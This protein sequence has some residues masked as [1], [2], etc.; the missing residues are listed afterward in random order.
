MR[1]KAKNSVPTPI[2]EG[3]LKSFG[4]TDEDELLTIQGKVPEEVSSRRKKPTQS[5]VQFSDVLSMP[6]SEQAKFFLNAMWP[7]ISRNPGQAERIYNEW[8]VFKM[9][10]KEAHNDGNKDITEDGTGVNETVARVFLEKL[11]RAVSASD[12]KEKFREIDS[13]SDGS[14]AWIEY[15]CYDN[16]GVSP[17][18]VIYRPQVQSSALYKSIDKVIAAER[19]LR[20]FDHDIEDLTEKSQL[21]GTEG[22]KY[23]ADLNKYKTEN[24]KAN[25]NADL[26]SAQE[27]LLRSFGKCKE[28]GT[29]FWESMLEKDREADKPQRKRK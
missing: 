27:G 20:Q 24:S 22:K 5:V 8:K 10:Q 2:K 13:N 11:K 18:T 3:E 25:L 4:Y 14:M 29:E 15:L 16:Q 23:T 19:A 28:L 26:A 21:P 6:A 1:R 17:A 12:F 9:V 7:E